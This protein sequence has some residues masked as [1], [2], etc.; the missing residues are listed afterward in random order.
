M[1]LCA[2]N[3]VLAGISAGFTREMSMMEQAVDSAWGTAQDAGAFLN[4]EIGAVA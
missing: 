3:Q 1:E 4:C 2:C